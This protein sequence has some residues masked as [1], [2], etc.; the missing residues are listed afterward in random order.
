LT[1]ATNKSHNY[2][3]CS[4]NCLENDNNSDKLIIIAKKE[5]ISLVNCDSVKLSIGT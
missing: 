3:F 2:T 5:R 4:T 1:V